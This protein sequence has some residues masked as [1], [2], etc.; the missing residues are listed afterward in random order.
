[1]L[2]LFFALPC[3]TKIAAQIDAWRQDQ[4]FAGKPVPAA[5]LH[6]TLAFLGQVPESRVQLLQRV[7]PKLALAD[8]AFDLNLDHLDCW[9]EG[10]LHLAPSQPP[11]TLLK[12]AWALQQQ[13]KL[14]GFT[15][16]SRP[17]RPHLT[18]A[19]NSR[20]AETRTVPSFAWR[21]DQLHIYHSA[22]GQYLSLQRWPVGQP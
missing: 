18:L 13:L 21:V 16:D 12:L 15:L 1:M 11:Q 2:R 10:L 6:V 19:R 9:P 4:H 17:Y 7:P 3:P 14:D 8:L 22:G 5:N 20:P